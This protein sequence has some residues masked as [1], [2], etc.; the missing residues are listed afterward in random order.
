MTCFNDAISREKKLKENGVYS[1]FEKINSA[2]ELINVAFGNTKHP[3]IAFSGG[4]DSLIV[5]DLV[6]RIKPEIV[7]VFCNTGNEYPETIRFVRTIDNVVWLKPLKTFKQ[8]T[9]EYGLPVIKSKAKRHGNYCCL[10]LKEKPANNYYKNNNVDLIFTGLTSDE[11]RNRMMMLK[12]MGPYYYAKTEKRYKCHPIYNWS[13]D[14]VWNYI[15]LKKLDYNAIYDK[16]MPRCGCR[17]CTAY[18][19]WKAVTKQYNI[20]DY[21]L[22]SKMK[23]REEGLTSIYDFE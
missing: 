7:A 21:E 6:R 1:L 10:W 14:D 20:K 13:S 4:K 12:R 8:C 22:L 23:A 17:L 15:K 18:I 3:V 19:S 16:G 9:E 2:N 5:L 11:S